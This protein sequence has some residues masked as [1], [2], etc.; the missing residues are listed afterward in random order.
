LHFRL[1]GCNQ[2]QIEKLGDFSSER[3]FQTQIQLFL[4]GDSSLL[5]L[6]AD[7]IMDK[8]HIQHAKFLVDK[9]FSE[10]HAQVFPR[11]SQA[12]NIVLIIHTHREMESLTGF[13]FLSGWQQVTL[14]QLQKE[15]TDL[16]YTLSLYSDRPSY[17]K[18]L[19]ICGLALMFRSNIWDL[20]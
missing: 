14:D 3:Q 2:A 15:E 17:T 10:Y 8:E 13:T 20:I 5:I 4:T 12:K 19:K 16:R 9:N 18:F 6:Q 11:P 7:A 1:N